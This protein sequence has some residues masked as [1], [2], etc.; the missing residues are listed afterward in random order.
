MPTPVYCTKIASRLTRTYTD[1]HGLKDL[2][3]E[4]LGVDLSKQQQSSDWGARRSD[5]GATRLRRVRRAAPARAARATRRVC[6]RARTASA[7]AQACFEFPAVAG[8]TRSR[9]LGR[10]GHIFAL[11]A[12]AVPCRPRRNLVQNLANRQAAMDRRGV[13]VPHAPLSHIVDT[14]PIYQ[15]RENCAT[16]KFRR[17]GSDGDDSQAREGVRVGPAS[18]GEREAA[19]PWSTRFKAQPAT[20][21]CRPAFSAPRGTAVACDFCALRFRR[22]G[23]S[24]ALASSLHLGLQSVPHA[25]HS[26]RSTSAIWWCRHQ[27]HHEIAAP[28]RLFAR[29][30]R[31]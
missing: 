20:L 17:I 10:R 30:A 22:A 25:A 12:L 3:R 9:G 8:P 11:I 28:V 19:E 27:G 5:R 23:R 1:R 7:L 14:R 21:R 29:S 31:L 24:L 6:W 13:T 4:L 18:H 2:V 15:A 26:C 16:A